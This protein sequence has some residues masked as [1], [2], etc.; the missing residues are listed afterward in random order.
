MISYN[1]ALRE[2]IKIKTIIVFFRAYHYGRKI[3]S[4]SCTCNS[5]VSQQKHNEYRKSEKEKEQDTS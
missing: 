1:D 5:S 2:F 4:T 3:N